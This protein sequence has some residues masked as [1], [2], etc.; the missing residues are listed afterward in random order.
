MAT[1]VY[2]LLVLHTVHDAVTSVLSLSVS[3]ALLLAHD[4]EAAQAA[5]ELG[6]D[7]LGLKAADLV[8]E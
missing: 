6:L 2:S 4:L 3:V 8:T 7:K 1:Y 5:Y